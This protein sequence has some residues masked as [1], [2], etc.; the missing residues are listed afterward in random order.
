MK[1]F[2]FSATMLFLN[3]L[4]LFMGIFNESALTIFAFEA[5]TF[6]LSLLLMS[7]TNGSWNSNSSSG[8]DFDDFDA[9]DD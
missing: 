9:F 8:F 7:P 1:L 2:K 5:F 3:I 6:L 4:Y